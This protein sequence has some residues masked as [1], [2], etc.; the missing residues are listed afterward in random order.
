MTSE[1]TRQAALFPIYTKFLANLQI[2]EWG[3]R[4][5][6]RI[7]EIICKNQDKYLEVSKLTGVPWQFVGALHHMECGGNFSQ[8]LANGD[9]IDCPTVQVPTGIPAGTWVECAVVALQ[10][11]GKD[12]RLSNNIDWHDGLKWLWRAE[13]YNGFGY[14]IDH[15]D[16][17][18][19]Y[20]W[21]GTNHY[22]K[23]K[24][25]KDGKWDAGTVSKQVGAVPI[26]A[27]LGVL[28]A[29]KNII[30]RAEKMTE[31]INLKNVFKH[32]K[33]L[34]HQLAAVEELQRQIPEEALAKFAEMWR[35]A[36][37]VIAPQF[38]NDFNAEQFKRLC[39]YAKNGAANLNV[40]TTYYSQ[41]DNYTMSGRT[42]NSSSSAMY[43]DW[44]RRATGA[45]PL[46]G[47]DDYLRSVLKIGDT[48][49]H[50]N[51]TAA[52]K[53][54]GFTTKWLSP[55][56][57]PSEADF[58]QVDALLDDGFPVPVN[59]NHRGSENAPKGGHIVMLISR[60]KS[61]GTYICHD[62]YGT[63]AS[64]YNEPNGRYSPISRSAFRARWQGGR[65]VLA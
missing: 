32:W 33:E 10:L 45:E 14:V 9:P 27:S 44:L 37:A 8:H 64:D 6:D 63:L 11:P 57:D 16:V 15:P 29:T 24:Y 7:A 56:N 38:S 12:Y 2:T 40:K 28:N 59:I 47:D 50:E 41:R 34:P 62:P 46:G 17:L 18:S 54:Y 31:L 23:G 25:V 4:E 36:P 30:T 22:T 51:Q 65:R 60:R 35:S 49:Y 48:I 52:I 5:A 1:K 53:K 26:W 55:E 58:A 13:Q 20:L 3:K 61:E 21:S 42:C 19:P 39:S 43:L